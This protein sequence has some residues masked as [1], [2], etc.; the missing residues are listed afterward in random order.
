MSGRYDIVSSRRPEDLDAERVRLVQTRLLTLSGVLSIQDFLSGWFHGAP[1]ETISRDNV[2]HYIA[3][4]FHD[5]DY[6]DL[7]LEVQHT[8][9]SADPNLY[10]VVNCVDDSLCVRTVYV[11]VQLYAQAPMSQRKCNIRLMQLLAIFKPVSASWQTGT[12]FMLHQ[13]HCRHSS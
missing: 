10:W 8:S 4:V 11:A 5:A 3:Y 9:G 13:I 7:T 12:S 1:F 6:R 2:L